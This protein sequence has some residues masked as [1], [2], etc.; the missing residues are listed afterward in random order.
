[1]RCDVVS[2]RDIH[3]ADGRSFEGAVVELLCAIIVPCAKSDVEHAHRQ[4]AT[5][6]LT[7]VVSQ[8]RQR[9]AFE[10]LVSVELMAHNITHTCRHPVLVPGRNNV[11]AFLWKYACVYVHISMCVQC[12]SPQHGK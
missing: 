3:C 4:E 1:V 11:C 7:L 8:R 9:S 5:E 6:E 2:E 10:Q 12:A